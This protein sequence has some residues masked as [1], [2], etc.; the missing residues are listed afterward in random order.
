MACQEGHR[1]VVQTLLGAGADVNIARSNVSDVMS[2]CSSLNILTHVKLII[3]TYMYIV[4]MLTCINEKCVFDL[5]GQYNSIVYGMSERS[6]WCSADF[7]GSRCRCEYSN[8]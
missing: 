3:H 8:I 4:Y 2:T 5:L 6:P 7:V 1:D